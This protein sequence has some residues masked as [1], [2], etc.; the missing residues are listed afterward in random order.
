MQKKHI[1]LGLGGA[2]GG[3]IAMKLIMRPK[4]VRFEE[5]AD[6]IA[7]SE[8]SKFVDV[9]GVE[10][11]YQ[12]FGEA[13]NPTMILVHG[14]TASTYVWKSVAPKFAEEG[15][16]VIAVDLVGFGFSQKPAWFDYRIASQARMISR[17]MN[18]LGIGK[19]TLVGS[20]FGGAVCSWVTLD[21]P[22]RVEKLVLVGSVINDAPS[23]NAIFKVLS[24]PGIG[25]SLSPFLIDS[26]AFLK[27]RMHGTLDKTNH[28]LITEERIDSVIRPLRAADAHNSL[29][30]TARNWDADR[31][32]DDAHLI[33]QPTLLIWG[34]NDEVIPVKHG[35]RLYDT[36]LNSRFVVLKDC[37]HVPP[38]EAPELFAELVVEFC[39]DSKGHI[40]PKDTEKM[41]LSQVES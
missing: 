40:E 10:I 16:H 11:H 34:E 17:F 41:E 14:Y 8:N 13:G 37:G 1:A 24:V 29:L 15:F 6:R 30:T 27:M 4:T 19:A 22:E 23:R 26:K 9:D 5:V 2:I 7:H 21:N 12:E 32:Q 39:R 3:A 33:E 20:S 35:E 38:E 25:E 18:R 31:I 36:I 28:D